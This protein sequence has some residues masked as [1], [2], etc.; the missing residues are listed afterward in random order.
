MPRGCRAG[1]WHDQQAAGPGEHVAAYGAGPVVILAVD[2][3]YTGEHAVAAGVVFDDWA[4]DAIRSSHVSFIDRVS[5]YEPGYFYKR[6][7]PCILELINE[8]HLA[9]DYILIDGYV[10]LDGHA[11]PGLG[12]YLYDALQH[13]AKIIGVAKNRFRGTAD[14]CAVYRGGSKRPLYVTCAGM[15]LSTARKRVQSMSGSHRYPALL[16]RVDQICR[17]AMT[18]RG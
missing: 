3:H 5:A 1:G 14:E 4:D 9:P 13:R 17:A 2:V 18:G 8:H 16:K 6:E 15:Q 7:L 12:S 10:Y 11:S